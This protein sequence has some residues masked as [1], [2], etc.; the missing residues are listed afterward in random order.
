M[1]YGPELSLRPAHLVNFMSTALSM[2]NSGLGLTVCMP[3]A[4]PLVD[5]YGLPIRQLNSPA[6]YRRFF[7]YERHARTLPPA[8]EQFKNALFSFMHKIS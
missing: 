5:L 2:V 7:I 6:V 1:G 4:R 8:A 3:Y